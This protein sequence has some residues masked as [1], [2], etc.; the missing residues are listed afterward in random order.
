MRLRSQERASDRSLNHFHF[1]YFWLLLNA[2]EYQRYALLKTADFSQVNF[3]GSLFY[4]IVNHHSLS[5][6]GRKALKN[7]WILL[8]ISNVKYSNKFKKKKMF[9]YR[10]QIISLLTKYYFEL[11]MIMQERV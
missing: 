9:E 8:V 6:I 1:H 4:K 5:D 3:L 11:N 2:N 10:G 7:K